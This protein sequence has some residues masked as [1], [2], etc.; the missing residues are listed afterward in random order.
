MTKRPRRATGTAH[1][2]RDPNALVAH[3]TVLA[4]DPEVLHAQAESS[5]RALLK[6]G[7]SANTVRSYGSALRYWAA[8]YRL[9]YR[10]ALPLP[11]P[12]PAVLQFL[13]DHVERTAEDGTLVHDLPAAIDHTLV[14]GGFKGALGAPALNTVLHRLA[15]LSKAHQMRD[16]PNPTRDP[17]V[18]ELARRIRRAY[19]TRGVRPVS[20]TALTKDPLEALLTTCTDGLIG[21]RDR[22]LLLFA[23]ASGG[24]RRSEVAA[25]VIENLVKVDVET[26]VYRLTH[27]KTDQTGTDHNIHADKPIVGPAA[28]ALTAW[29][30]ASGV[31]SGAI[32]RRIRKTKAVEPL[33]AQAVWH[34]VKRRAALAGL[35]EDFGAHSLRSGFM[36]EAGRQNVPLGEAMALTGHRSAQTALRYFQTGA[37][38]HTKAANLLQGTPGAATVERTQEGNSD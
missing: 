28:A 13:V 29:L 4:L 22:A 6:E 25:A 32:F 19:A 21:T 17:A 11:V 33:S 23:W 37:V 26:Y 12:V 34:I 35:Q 31:T 5:V 1:R 15:V 7:E 20:K 14:D 3:A 16:V 9:R 27:S 30:G 24:R 10:A 38:Q 36:T 8:W 18:Q 2:S